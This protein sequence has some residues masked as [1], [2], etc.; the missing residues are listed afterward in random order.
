[1]G[2][3]AAFIKKPLAEKRDRTAAAAATRVRRMLWTF[4]VEK[5]ETK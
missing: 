2:I 1:M 4:S 3:G 5:Y